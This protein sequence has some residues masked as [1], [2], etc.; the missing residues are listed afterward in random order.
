HR[1]YAASDKSVQSASAA[2]APTV[3]PV[4]AASDTAHTRRPS[5]S[6]HARAASAYNAPLPSPAETLAPAA[7]ADAPPAP[8]ADHPSAR[9][10][11]P[12]V[13]DSQSPAQS[14]SPY[15]ATE[16]CASFAPRSIA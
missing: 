4:Q 14:H 5:A 13:H 11:K 2:P 1:L 6:L 16:R 9:T 15:P 3:P 12:R 7:S 10:P 8:Q